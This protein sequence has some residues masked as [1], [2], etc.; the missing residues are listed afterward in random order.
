MTTSL[1]V[2]LLAPV[3]LVHLEDGIE[4]CQNRRLHKVAFGSR[5]WELFRRLDE[6]REDQPVDVYIYASHRDVRELAATWHGRYIGHVESLPD[7]THPKGDK[8][9]PRS[10]HGETDHWGVF[11]EVE[12]LEPIAPMAIDEFRGYGA[13][14]DFG[15]PF[16]PE[17]PILIEHP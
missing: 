9:R 1:H 7:G 16:V 12:G 8:Y 11:W 2:A 4:L 3:P 13:E 10:T 5:A 14:K 6:L 15:Q 17:G